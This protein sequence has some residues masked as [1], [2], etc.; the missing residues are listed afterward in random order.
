MFYLIVD[1]LPVEQVVFYDQREVVI[2]CEAIRRCDHQC[3]IAL[4]SQF[5]KLIDDLVLL[6]EDI[7]NC[8]LPMGKRE[9]ENICK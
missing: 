8:S 9:K 4:T 7:I 3:S 6:C 5:S 2:L 1:G